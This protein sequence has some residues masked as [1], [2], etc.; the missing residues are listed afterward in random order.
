MTEKTKTRPITIDLN[1]FKLRIDL[2]NRIEVTLHFNSPS[3]KFY[4]CVIALVVNDM[5]RQGKLTSIPLEGYH[6]VLALLNDTV[7]ASA[8]SSDKENLLPR[9]Y[10]KW[11]HAL[12]N[13]EEAP[14]FKVLGRIKEYDE[15][16]GKT[17]PFTEAEKD[18]WANLFEYK[19]S[20]ENVRL[21]FAVDKIGASI[22]DIDIIYEGSSNGGAWERFLSSLRGKAE[23]A[24]ETKAI[25]S[26]SAVPEAPVSL[27]KEEGVTRPS[28][29][30]WVALAAA[31]TV[32]LGAGFLTAWKLYL[33]PAPVKTA[34]L[35]RMA[36]PLPDKPSIAVLPF[37]NMTGDPKQE[38]FSDG[39]TEDIITSLSKVPNIFVIARNST[40]TYKGKPVKVQQVAED[41]GIRYV[42]EGS[43]QRSGDRV[44]ISTQLIDALKGYHVW[45][46]RYD[47]EM[48]DIFALQDKIT[49]E[50]LKAV[51]VRLIGGKAAHGAGTDNL[52][53]YIKLLQAREVLD[54]ATKETNVQARQLF[55]GVIRLDPNYAMAYSF[56]A[57]VTA[58]DAF[59]GISKSSRDSTMKAIELNQK[60]IS[61]DDS[62]E[63][64]HAYLGQLYAMIGEYE[65][66]IAQCERAIAIAPNFADAYVFFAFALNVS[67]RAEEAIPVIEKAFRL[68]PL[69]PPYFY[70]QHAARAYYLV[71]RYEDAVRMN[72]K[73]L[74]R[75]PDNIF[76]LRSLVVT[77]AA[78]GRWDEARATTLNLVRMHPNFSVQQWG[79]SVSIAEKDP[80]VTERDM[81]L[82]RKAGLPD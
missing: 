70:Y 34:S 45:S 71:G 46:E 78:M 62:C 72:Q 79:R 7:G 9:I 51:D 61:L 10:R 58:T 50:T 49:F 54:Q 44:R 66:G 68:T 38:F 57:A 80:A 32:I 53:A 56:L 42:L 52:E 22:E 21:K 74:S 18:S 25:Q 17:Y 12:P 55:E 27:P 11:Q 65:K 4:L 39:L 13:L 20:E 81:E 19:G 6:D 64:A 63:G 23:N 8:G 35:E 30:R 82:M 43:V 3:R 26:P 77:Y 60:A 24:P 59:H 31:I 16:T 36:F 69:N 2:K 67:G 37:V 47:R 76:G 1:Q 75:W 33:K 14:L 28:R 40:F 15:G 48:T 5:K 29:L 41:L 73:L